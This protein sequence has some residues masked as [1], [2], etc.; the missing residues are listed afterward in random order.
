MCKITLSVERIIKMIWF[1]SILFTI[2]HYIYSLIVFIIMIPTFIL[3]WKC[4]MLMPIVWTGGTTILLRWIC[5]IKIKI[6][7]KENLPKKNGYIVA[8]KHQ[9]ALETNL[10]HNL[11]PNTFYVFKKELLWLPFA[12]LYA[13][14]TGCLPIDRNGGATAL[15]KMFIGATKRFKRGQNMVI[16]PEGTRTKPGE[17][18]TKPYSPGIALI[19]EHCNVPVIPVALNTG[20]CWP[21]NR[22]I[23][24]PGTIT[25][26]ILK[27]IEPG[28]PKREFLK[29]LQETI[30]TEQK[31][32]PLPNSY[33][34]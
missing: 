33:K 28:L 15:R 14:K 17:E 26:R 20:Y 31:A 29:V 22:F 30:E 4:A 3:P 23:R 1:R 2:V 10:F 11:I 25:V 8:S 21:K 6:E 32:L 19:Y 16:F 9:S 13:L 24:Y 18:T 5:G 12:G 7:G 27:P 34:G